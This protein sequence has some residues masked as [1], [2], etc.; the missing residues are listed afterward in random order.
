MSTSRTPEKTARSAAFAM[1]T[2]AVACGVCCV[3][4]FSI[5]AV[6]LASTG[7]ILAWFGGAQRG[8]NFLGAVVA[9]IAWG[10]LGWQSIRSK[11]RPAASTLYTMGIAT[12]VL[13]VAIA[14]PIIEPYIIRAFISSH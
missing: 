11:A 5:S 14:W 9:A 1:A 2:G 7:G 6:A 10:W 4:P 3:L 8:M 12:A 13:A